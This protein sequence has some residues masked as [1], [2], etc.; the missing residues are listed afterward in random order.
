MN[1]TATGKYAAPDTVNINVY[2][3]SKV[4]PFEIESF[5]DTRATTAKLTIPWEKIKGKAVNVSCE[6][7]GEHYS[8]PNITSSIVKVSSMF[9]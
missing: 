6:A 5:S 1:C 3:D 4:V 7:K 9:C 2:M 8:N